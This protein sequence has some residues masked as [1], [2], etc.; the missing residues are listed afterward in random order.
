MRLILALFVFVSPQVIWADNSMDLTE[1]E[2]EYR[3]LQGKMEGTP[4]LRDE[5]VLSET[6]HE[7]FSSLE[8]ENMKE[9][10]K[11]QCQKKLKK[12]KKFVALTLEKKIYFSRCYPFGSAFNISVSA[13]FSQW[14]RYFAE[15][16]FVY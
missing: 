11:K 10:A 14:V 9:K 13:P 15:V 12:L 16:R 2:K 5:I 8:Q 7:R 3:E 6:S 4:V 1:I